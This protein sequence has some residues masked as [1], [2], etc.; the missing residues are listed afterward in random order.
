MTFLQEEEVFPTITDSD[1]SEK[2]E[3]S[4]K[5]S[6]SEPSL[7]EE[8]NEANEANNTSAVAG[9]KRKFPDKQTDKKV[10]FFFPSCLYVNGFTLMYFLILVALTW[11]Q[12]LF[13]ETNGTFIDLI[14]FQ[15][16]NKP[17]DSW[18]ELKINTHVYVT[19][20]P[21][22]VTIDEVSVNFSVNLPECNSWC[23]N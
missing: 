13:W 6:V 10:N 20:L 19:G 17:P 3:D 11:K 14:L 2:L 9:G 15:E 4:S 5:L 8:A 16:A 1:A 23:N 7:K 18:F 12:Y 21:E 22:D